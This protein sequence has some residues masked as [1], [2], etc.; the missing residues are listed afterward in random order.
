MKYDK[1]LFFYKKNG[2]PM[3][4]LTVDKQSFPY[5]GISR[6]VKYIPSIP[7]KFEIKNLNSYVMQKTI[8]LSTATMQRKK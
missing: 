7:A 1:L 8:I 3:K 6:F 5:R 2:K 4:N